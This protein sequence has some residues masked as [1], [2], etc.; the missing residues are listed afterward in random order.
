MCAHCHLTIW[1]APDKKPKFCNL[2]CRV[3]HAYRQ[4][5]KTLLEPALSRKDADLA[6]Q[7]EVE[8]IQRRAARTGQ[9]FSKF[10]L[11]F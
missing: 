11:L 9:P 2:T 7:A 10:K 8:R 5:E 6:I 3:A 1:E 4:H